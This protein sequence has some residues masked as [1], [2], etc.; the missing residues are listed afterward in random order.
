MFASSAA[1]GTIAEE[2]EAIA[3]SP[4]PVKGESIGSTLWLDHVTLLLIPILC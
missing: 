3:T 2:S 4:D 1:I